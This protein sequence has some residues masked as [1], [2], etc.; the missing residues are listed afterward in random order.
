MLRLL[1]SRVT[2]S[3]SAGGWPT[4]SDAAGA[5][6]HEYHTRLIG[7]LHLLI[8]LGKLGKHYFSTLAA[9]SAPARG[10]EQEE[11]NERTMMQ[12]GNDEL[13][14]MRPAKT[15][16]TL[17]LCF[18]RQLEPAHRQNPGKDTSCHQAVVCRPE[19]GAEVHPCSPPLAGGAGWRHALEAT[20]VHDTLACWRDTGF[21]EYCGVVVV[22]RR[23]SQLHLDHPLA[24]EQVELATLLG[25]YSL[26]LVFHRLHRILP[27]L[28]GWPHRASVWNHPDKDISQKAV[29]DFKLG[30]PAF[31]EACAQKQGTW[32]TCT[33]S[34]FQLPSVKQLVEGMELIEWRLT[35]EAC[36]LMTKSRGTTIAQSVVIEE[37][38]G[39]GRGK[40][41]TTS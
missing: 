6:D 8:M 9:A 38:S 33:K 13:K 39:G 21:L 34:N 15:P 41:A 14:K 29:D 7:L 26:Q 24:R 23:Y 12:Q 40:A 2:R 16:P 36:E 32:K 19:Q 1:R 3:G 11:A 5:Q 30:W 35:P 31:K 22:A 4:H 28:Q 17:Q 20:T 10:A 25:E 27:L 18:F 37:C